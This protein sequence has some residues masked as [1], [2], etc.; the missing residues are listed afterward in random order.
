VHVQCDTYRQWHFVCVINTHSEETLHSTEFLLISWGYLRTWST[1]FVDELN[2]TTREIFS[3]PIYRT[4]KEITNFCGRTL[5]VYFI[6]EFCFFCC[7]VWDI[8]LASL[9][10]M[11]RESWVT[12]K[13]HKFLMMKIFFLGCLLVF[14]NRGLLKV[15][16][17]RTIM[18]LIIIL[19]IHSIHVLIFRIM[20]FRSLFQ[21]IRVSK[22]PISYYYSY[23]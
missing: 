2:N 22:K 3:F 18:H 17:L 8:Y 6:L 5:I 7:I 14:I 20:R 4:D 11:A 21:L 10:D 12:R 9:E 23:S 15:N 1:F 19:I 16:F 13:V